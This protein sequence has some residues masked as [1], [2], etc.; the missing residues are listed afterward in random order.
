[1]KNGPVTATFETF[2]DISVYKSGVYSHVTGPSQGYHA[3]KIV[4]W[5]ITE[6]TRIRYWIIV[7]SWNEEYG[8]DGIILMKRGKNECKIES[9][10]IASMP[11]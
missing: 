9:E 10:I 3:I 5:G 2:E 4:G 11:K 8:M 6:N 1:M 7:N